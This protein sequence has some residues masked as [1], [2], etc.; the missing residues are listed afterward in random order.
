MTKLKNK[1]EE[2][3]TAANDVVTQAKNKLQETKT[4]INEVV[5]HAKDTA[6]NNLHETHK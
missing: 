1:V 6:T 3:Q 2:A 4:E 5:N